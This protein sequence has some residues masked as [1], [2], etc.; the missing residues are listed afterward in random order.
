MASWWVSDCELELALGGAFRLRF[1]TDQPADLQGSEGCRVLSWLPDRMLS[2]SWN[3]PP[4]L[5]TR[6]QR[7]LVVIELSPVAGGT[8][9]CLTHH[10]WPT[11]GL[12]DA[13]TGW[14]QT[15]AYFQRAWAAVLERLPAVVL[16][17]APDSPE[18]V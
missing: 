3:A 10:G 8:R 14:P 6:G 15:F 12:A 9:L 2:F 7:T 1:D 16:G 13:S 4:H 5:P 11:A 17:T 18:D